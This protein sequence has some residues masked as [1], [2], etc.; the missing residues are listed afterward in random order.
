MLEIYRDTDG[1][2]GN[3][4]LPE[5]FEEGIQKLFKEIENLAGE[6][7]NLIGGITPR[8]IEVLQELEKAEET[9]RSYLI[10]VEDRLRQIKE[11]MGRIEEREEELQITLQS[12][13]YLT[14]KAR[15]A[16]DDA[17]FKYVFLF[18]ILAYLELFSSM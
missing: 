14:N 3:R 7:Y 15:I 10:D 4:E 16:T 17:L 1:F 6:I 12:I 18:K 13:F 8:Q 5:D 11:V 9:I 2:M